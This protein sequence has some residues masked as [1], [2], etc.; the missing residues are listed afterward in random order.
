MQT[1]HGTRT[2]RLRD[3]SR[4]GSRIEGAPPV[5]G[6]GSEAIL[7]CE[8]LDVFATVRWVR[9]ELCG[10]KFAAPISDATLRALEAT[11]E[12]LAQESRPSAGR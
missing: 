5:L 12:R 2:V 10:I 4:W 7:K 11:S 9:G 8:A 6:A 3:V 1:L